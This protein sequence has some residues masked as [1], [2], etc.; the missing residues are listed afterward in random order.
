MTHAALTPPWLRAPAVVLYGP[1]NNISIP[2]AMQELTRKNIIQEKGKKS[3]GCAILATWLSRED[4]GTDCLVLLLR[5]QSIIL[6]ADFGTENQD[7]SMDLST[8][9]ISELRRSS[10]T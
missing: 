10:I 2:F 8:N 4:C 1:N 7:N 6:P 5:K 9:S 3:T